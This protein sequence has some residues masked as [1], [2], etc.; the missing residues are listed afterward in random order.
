MVEKQKVSLKLWAAHQLTYTFPIL[1]SHPVS[2]YLIWNK[3]LRQRHTMSM[4]N[5][6]WQNST[7]KMHMRES[8]KCFRHSSSLPCDP[9]ISFFSFIMQ[10][11]K[12]LLSSSSSSSV[13]GG[14]KCNF[15]SLYVVSPCHAVYN[16]SIKPKFHP[17]GESSRP[18]YSLPNLILC[19]VICVIFTG[20]QNY[21]R[22][23]FRLWIC[24]RP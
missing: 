20:S 12:C 5:W 17:W 18:Q 9:I 24:S 13:V 15:G 2:L 14:G 23:S 21:S 4:W 1:S 6:W 7:H 22:Q 3:Q 8:L 19:F 16:K 10:T 11:T